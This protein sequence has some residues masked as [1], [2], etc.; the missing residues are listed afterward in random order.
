MEVLHKVLQRLA[1]AHLTLNREKCYFC[2]PSLKYLGYIGDG[3]GLHVDPDK[4]SAIV[5][6]VSPRN[7][8]KVHQF[9]RMASWYQRFIPNFATVAA[10]LSTLLRK[11][12]KCEWSPKCENAFHS[13]KK[14]LISAPIL[15]CPNFDLPFTVQTDASG[16]EIGAVLTQTYPDGEHVISYV[17]RSLVFPERNYS[18]TQR[19]CLAVILAIKK[20]RG[21]LEGYHFTVV[22]NHYS[23]IWLKNL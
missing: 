10:P 4:V 18:T 2:R 9:L 14:L 17:S 16:F 8:K 23:L 1:N 6:I 7:V 20:F 12:K 5:S 15:T 11:N 19:E 13:I 3:N 21:Y 22:T